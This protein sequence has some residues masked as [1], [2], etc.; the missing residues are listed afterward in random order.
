MLD[1]WWDQIIRTRLW[2]EEGEE[3]IRTELYLKHTL[4]IQW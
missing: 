1:Y 3:K 2:S 4:K